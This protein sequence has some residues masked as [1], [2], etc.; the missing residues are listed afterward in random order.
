MDYVN[1]LSR[2]VH[3]GTAVV[4]VGGMVFL[5]F[6]LMPAAES[7]PED[8]HAGLRERIMARW[9][10]FV[11]IGIALLLISGFYNYIA[12]AIPAHKGDKLYHPLM[13]VKILL[14]FVVFFLGSAL[15][16]RSA[17]FEQ[18]RRN[19]RKWIVITLV[20]AGLVIAIGGYLKVIAKPT[21]ADGKPIAA[22]PAE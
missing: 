19:A 9:R 8:V 3:V 7:L 15:A 1:V 11:M 6:A 2:W 5:R 10:K 17:A 4:L 14:G 20:L 18:L 12:V 16:G 22:T 21:S 13:G